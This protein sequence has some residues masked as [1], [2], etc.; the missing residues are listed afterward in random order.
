MNLDVQDAGTLLVFAEGGALCALPAGAV[1]EVVFLPE[2]TRPPGMP[3]LLEGVMTLD[4]KAVPVLKVATLLGLP[5]A[6]GG[7][8]TPALVLKEGRAALA[9]ERMVDIF[10]PKNSELVPANEGQSFNGCV[11]GMAQTKEGLVHILSAD[12]LLL[13]EEQK[14][15]AEFQSL[16][17]ARLEDGNGG[18]P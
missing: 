4:G 12:R 17:Q 1:Q 2:L 14:R 7:V 8:Y 16:A 18:S 11:T 3:S 10:N 6:S 13:A 9:V 15:I 5:V